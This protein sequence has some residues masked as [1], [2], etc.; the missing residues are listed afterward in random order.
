[1]TLPDSL[2]YF[3]S[4]L[5]AVGSH[6]ERPNAQI[7]VAVSGAS[8]VPERPRLEVSLWKA[9]YT[10]DLVAASGTL[11]LS[12]LAADQ[13][14]L[15]EPLG[16]QS[17]RDGDKLAAV[18]YE[19]TPAGDPWFPGAVARI[20]CEV[21]DGLDLGDATTYVCAVR[22][23]TRLRGDHPISWHEAR[24]RLPAEFI[25]RWEAKS[26]RDRELAAKLMR[27]PPA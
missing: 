3:W 17:G 6:G 7:C 22:E 9:N 23:R 1:M 4:P 19:L 8:I 11:V 27:W 21:I 24:A 16:L 10:H 26:A 2:S 13:L 14:D 15:L 25:A 18:D 5:C 12:L 20:S